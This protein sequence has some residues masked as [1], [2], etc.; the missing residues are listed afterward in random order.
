VAAE[1]YNNTDTSFT[2]QLVK[3]RNANPDFFYAGAIGGPTVLIFKQIKQLKLSMP[4]GLH[5]S[6]FNRA[7][8]TAI[9]GKAA[10]EGVYTPIER[11]GLASTATGVAG[12]LYAIAGTY[13]GH[14]A[15]NLNTAGFDTGLI[16]MEAVNKSDGT[17]DGIRDALEAIVDL[18]VIGGLVTYGPD[19]HHNKDER[20]VTVGQLVGGSFVEAR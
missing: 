13:L 10:A 4:L 12:R 6:A 18:Q 19:N 9:G 15:T 20:S 8:Y 7:F 16:M 2:A 5:S 17:R 1:S 11:E 14:P 3:I